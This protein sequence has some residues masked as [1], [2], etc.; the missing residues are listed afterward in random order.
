MLILRA[1]IVTLQIIFFFYLLLP[2]F[3]LIIHYI[4]KFFAPFKSPLLNKTKIDKEFSF[5]IV[6][7]AHEDEKNIPPFVDSLLKQSYQNF[8]VYVVADACDISNLNY[9]DTRISILKPEI[10]LNAKIKSLKFAIDHMLPDHDV[11]IVFDA[12]NLLHPN[13]L[14]VLNQYFRMG[15]LAVQSHM[16]SKNTKS[17]YAKLDT[18]G[19]VYYNFTERQMPMELGLSAHTLGLGIAVDKTLF[20]SM[21]Y[22]DALGGFDKKMQAD[23]VLKTPQI[24]FASEAIV[25]DEKVDD[26]KTLEKQRTRWIFTYFHYFKYNANL[27]LQGLKHFNFNWFYFGVTCLKP[28]LF[29]LLGATF[30]LGLLDIWIYLPGALLTASV[31]FFYVLTFIL[32]IITQS[33]QKGVASGLLYLPKFVFRQMLALVKIKKATKSF[34]KTDH[35]VI[36]Y[37]DDI[38]K[39]ES[40]H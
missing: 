5:A 10:P 18:I 26:G 15:Y 39:D 19:H 20:V 28:P 6:L 13:Y 23:L 3:L 12:D 25:Y 2:L 22:K 17:T 38:L 35:N 37:I 4:K 8:H 40:N 27:I 11:V 36:V 7:T 9:D 24:A 16:Y 34:L 32:I 33:K 29:I 1:L 14:S 30:L 21:I 31:I